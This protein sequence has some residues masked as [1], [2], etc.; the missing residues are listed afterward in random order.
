MKIQRTSINNIQFETKV[1]DESLK[2]SLLRIGISIPVRVSLT[3]NGY[4]CLDGHKR[5]SAIS[6]I[7]KENSNHPKFQTIRIVVVN[8]GS[9]RTPNGWERMNHH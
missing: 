2:N 5:L 8:D 4:R 1:Y 9:L 7:L 6:D 3:E